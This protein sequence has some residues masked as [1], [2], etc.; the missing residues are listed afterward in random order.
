[1]SKNNDKINELISV[2]QG[3]A[4]YLDN[5]MFKTTSKFNGKPYRPSIKGILERA[6]K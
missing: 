6:V 2:V 5:S 4:I 3:R 1:M